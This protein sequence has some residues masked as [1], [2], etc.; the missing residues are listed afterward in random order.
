MGTV[1]GAIRRRMEEL[2]L[3]RPLDAQPHQGDARGRPRLPRPVRLQPGRFFALA[4]SPQVF[5]QLFM[6]S[7][8]DRY[9]QIAACWRNEDLRADPQFEFRQARHRDGVRRARDVLD[10]LEEAVGASFRRSSARRRRGRSPRLTWHDVMARYGSDKPDLRFGLEI[11]DATELTAVPSRRLLGRRDRPLHHGAESVLARGA[12][13]ARRARE[14][15][16]GERPRLS[17][18]RRE[19]GGALAD[20]QVPLGG[21]ARALQGGA[22]LDRALRRGHTDCNQPRPRRAANAPRPRARSGRPCPGRVPLG[23]RL[24]GLR[25]G[26]AERA[27]HVSRTIPFTGIRAGDEEL[28]ESDPGRRSARR[29]TS[30]WNGWE[31]GSGS[32][33]IHDQE[34]QKRIFRALGLTDEELDEKFGF[35]LDA[36]KMGAPPHG[37]F[38]MGIERFCALLAGEPTSRGRSIPGFQRIRPS[39]GA[40]TPMP[41]DSA[42][43]RNHAP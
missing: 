10:V 42:R 15:V 41:E 5:K 19:R 27:L 3:R 31:L 24:P 7:G 14:G 1:V 37:G 29:T 30:V 36:L 22:R 25:M 8:F 32:I 28:I 33:R 11:E 34:V 40:P 20:R 13:P 43:T 17:R 39:S 21:R 16:G 26:R 38:A 9:Y 4:Q 18:R 12:R 6:I 2:R 23:G 35:L